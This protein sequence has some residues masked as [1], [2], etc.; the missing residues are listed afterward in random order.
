MQFSSFP[1][2]MAQGVKLAHTLRL[3]GRTFRKGRTL[4]LKD[5]D[6][7]RAQGMTEV[8]GARLMAGELDEDQAASNAARLLAGEHLEA[9]PAAHG[10]CNLKALAAGVLLV[11]AVAIDSLNGTDEALTVGTLMPFAPVRAGQVVATVKTIPFA[12]AGRTLAAWREITAAA[13]PLR[14]APFRARRAALIMT[15]TEGLPDKLFATTAAVTRARLGVLGS[16]LAFEQ[17]CQH[18]SAAVAEAIRSV[19]EQ[20]AELILIAGASVSKDRR[21][22]VPA[23]ITQAGGDIVHFGMPVEP[24]NMLLYA[25]IGTVPVINL[26]GCAR[27][28]RTNGLD[29]LLHR[30]LAGV[31]VSRAD[32]M[33]MGVGGLIASAAEGKTEIPEAPVPARPPRIA[34]IV[35]AA[36]SS[37]RMGERNKLCCTVDG[38]PMVRR[39]VAAALGSRCVQT[40]VVTGHEA[41]AVEDTLQGTA[42]SLVHNAGFATGMAS[43]LRCGLRALPSDL[44]GAIILLGDMP[45]LDTDHL[46]SLLDTFDPAAPAIIAPERDGRRG[47]PV[48]WP[49]SYFAEMQALQGDQGAR[50]MVKKYADD[51]VLVTVEDDAIFTDVDT[52]EELAQM[53]E[54]SA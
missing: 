35:L 14:I 15:V 53:A 51:M 39:V 54:Q 3:D 18:D 27:S 4:S 22:T 41:E 38:V 12:V 2:N 1:L 17:R 26:P 28:R 24:G 9:Q 49:R 8:V 30:L 50:S 52:P 40:L 42:V 23:G 44:D 37:S 34:A 43:S 10:R 46:N 45:K 21:D 7:L 29:W 19:L 48:L 33:N 11:D 25:Q 6:M 32:I 31:P 13:P 20:G 16:E 36:G 47:N 5:I